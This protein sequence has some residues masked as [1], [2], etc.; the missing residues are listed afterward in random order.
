MFLPL[1]ALTLAVPGGQGFGQGFGPSL[2]QPGPPERFVLTL[3]GQGWSLSFEAPPLTN[4]SGQTT[5]SGFQFRGTWPGGFNV[6][7]T[8][9]KAE[10]GGTRHD[11][12]FDHYWPTAQRGPILDPSTVKVDKTSGRYVKVSYRTKTPAFRMGGGFGPPGAGSG[13]I[14]AGQAGASSTPATT[15][16]VNYYFTV[17]GRWVDVHVSRTPSG[18]DDQEQLARF[19]RSLNYRDGAGVR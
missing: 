16:H 9:E 15:P 1:L 19:E 4:L 10:G 12:S 14:V 13:Q 3:P 11:D 7:V 8:S 18:P 2:A 17:N 5:R 6:S